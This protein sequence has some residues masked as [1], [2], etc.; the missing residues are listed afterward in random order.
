[1]V[2]F[3]AGTAIGYSIVVLIGL[4]IL[5]YLIMFNFYSSYYGPF[6]KVSEL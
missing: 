6:L 1:M 2:E 4:A 3:N 5:V